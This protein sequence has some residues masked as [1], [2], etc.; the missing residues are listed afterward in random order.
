MLAFI[1]RYSH[2]LW[3]LLYLFL[4]YMPWFAFLEGNVTRNYHLIHMTIDD[5]L[6]FHEIFVIPY[7][8]WFP[9]VFGMIL[10]FVF[11][12]KNDYWKLFSFLAIGMTVFLAVSTFYPN[13]CLLRP[14]VFPRDNILT[15]LVIKLYYSDTNTNLFP[16]IHVYN[17][18][19]VHFA[20][21]NSKTL[22]KNVRVRN[23]SFIMCT[24]IILSTVCL[25]QH[26]VFDVLTAFLMATVMYFLIYVLDGRSVFNTKAAGKQLS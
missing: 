19:G 20:V 23:A 17:S 14:S 25:K 24:L 8:L 26:S 18:L 22:S 10:Y 21:L 12:N 7:L 4:I 5:F 2:G 11:N 13:G 16:S 6:P 9:Y 3:A 1:K 15:K